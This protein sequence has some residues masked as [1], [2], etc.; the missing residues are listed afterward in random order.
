M[1][2]AKIKKALFEAHRFIDAVKAL[3]VEMAKPKSSFYFSSYPKESGAIK[4][5]SMDLT[6]ALADMRKPN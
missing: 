1:N 4:R 3:N 2:D 5:A 6:R